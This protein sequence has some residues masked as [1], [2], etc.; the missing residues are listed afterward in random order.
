M[1]AHSRWL[2]G[3]VTAAGGFLIALCLMCNSSR[4]D[5]DGAF[6]LESLGAIEEPELTP[7][8]TKQ[9]P[10]RDVWERLTDNL[11]VAVDLSAR[12]IVG[13]DNGRVSSIAFAGID[14]Y[15]VFSLP[16]GDWGTL[17]AQLYLT[18]IDNFPGPPAPFFEGGDD[19]EAVFR[20]FNF[21]YTGWTSRQYVNF[22]VGHFEIP[23]GLEQTLNTNGTLRQYTHGFNIGV[24][25]D[26][27]ASVNGVTQSLEYEIG[28]TRGTGNEWSS[29]GD[30][31]CVAARVGTSTDENWFAGISLMQGEILNPPSAARA[32]GA[33]TIVR[34]WRVGLDGMVQTGPFGLLGEASFGEDFQ[35]EV[36]NLL[37]EIHFQN[38]REDLLVYVQ[39]RSYHQHLATGWEDTTSATAGVRYSP[40]NHW[41]FS[42]QFT[43]NLSTFSNSER[44]GSVAIQVRYRF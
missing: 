30:P 42:F 36:V 31:Y 32:G 11:R 43:Q 27:G 17:I 16:E 6:S 3:R 2:R 28:L 38:N 13:T 7:E 4:A 25:A 24:K 19:T 34:R 37:I 1:F 12:G 10:E 21:N 8:L 15:K 9:A 14:V 5:D 20:I 22:R 26:W 41:A 33:S 39:M 23:F 18:R 44:N 40:D 29:R 35:Q